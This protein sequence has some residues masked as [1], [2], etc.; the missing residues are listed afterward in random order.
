MTWELRGWNH[1]MQHRTQAWD[2]L[3]RVKC[4]RV[5]RLQRWNAGEAERWPAREEFKL[6]YCMNCIQY[7]VFL[8]KPDRIGLSF[9][10]SRKDQKFCRL[11]SAALQF[12][13]SACGTVS[14]CPYGLYRH[15]DTLTDL[16]ET[17]MAPTIC[18]SLVQC[19]TGSKKKK[20][21]MKLAFIFF[22]KKWIYPLR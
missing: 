6:F 19:F 3:R 16:E 2:H 10:S 1:C 7:W 17:C 5:W 14:A 15:T 18:W 4:W 13:D 22:S 11:F 8:F 12:I 9:G 20:K 21:K